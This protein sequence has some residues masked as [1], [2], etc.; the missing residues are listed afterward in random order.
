MDVAFEAGAVDL[1]VC[2][3]R[4]NPEL[5]ATLL[6][7]PSCVDR[8]VYALTRAGD[9]GLAT[10]TGREI[11]SSLDP[12]SSL[13]VREREV[14]DLVCVGLSNREIGK[15]LF[16]SEGTVKVHVHNMFDKVGVRSRTALAMNALHER[17]RQATPIIDT[18]ELDN[19][20]VDLRR[21]V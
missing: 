18:G 14:Y 17:T 19:P 12:R 16:I 11:A 8:T 21:L 10:A 2:T 1:L 15:R 9:S 13:S 3:Y 6:S 4:A 5:L 20:R 7:A